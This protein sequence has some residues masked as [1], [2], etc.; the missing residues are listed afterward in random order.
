MR[1]DSKSSESGQSGDSGGG[2]DN[3]DNGELAEQLLDLLVYA[4]IGLALE[5]KDLIPK[6]VD[7]GRGQVSLMR[8]AGKVASNRGRNYS[9]PEPSVTMPIADY[10]TS[11][12]ADL[13]PK[14][15]TLNR[16]Q[17]TYVLEYE[18]QN[19]NRKTVVNRINALLKEK[20]QTTS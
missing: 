12:A 7:R 19:R 4:P 16:D 20:T 17:L 9:K 5:A 8:L 11:T 6:L 18:Q 14:L 10:D 13:L 2:G 15:A 3:G 1:S